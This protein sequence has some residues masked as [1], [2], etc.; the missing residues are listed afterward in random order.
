MTTK[1]SQDKAKFNKAIRDLKE[2]LSNKKTISKTPTVTTHYSLWT[3]TMKI[4][5]T[6]EPNPL[7]RM[8]NG[9]WARTNKQIPQVFAEHPAEVLQLFASEITQAKKP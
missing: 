3:A 7:I 9:T 8:S 5:K 6:Y 4:K 2:P 1:T